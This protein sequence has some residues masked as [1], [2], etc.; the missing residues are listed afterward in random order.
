MGKDPMEKNLSITQICPG[1]II[2]KN[3]VSKKNSS[4]NEINNE[5]IKKAKN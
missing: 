5:K 1:I 3:Q 2:S 4:D